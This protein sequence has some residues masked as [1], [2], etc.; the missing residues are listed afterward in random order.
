[1]PS[2][3]HKIILIGSEVS[4]DACH[5]GWSDKWLLLCLV[6]KMRISAM[7]PVQPRQ[8][9]VKQASKEA[10]HHTGRSTTYTSAAKWVGVH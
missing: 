10:V 5:T 2:Q 3:K 8:R 7:S 6:E 4:S 9:A 1:M